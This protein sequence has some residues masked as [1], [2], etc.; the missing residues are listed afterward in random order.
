[1]TIT[2]NLKIQ[3]G[4]HFFLGSHFNNPSWKMAAI[5]DF[6]EG[7]SHFSKH[8]ARRRTKDKFGACLTICDFT[9]RFIPVNI[10]LCGR[11]GPVLGR[12]WQHRPRTGPVLAC[13]QGLSV[14]RSY[15]FCYFCT[16]LNTLF[17]FFCVYF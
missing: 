8:C 1:M 4:G 16:T 10:T 7:N 15:H 11:T 17:L 13:L 5:L 12:C 6:D 3:Y 2:I 9:L 14:M